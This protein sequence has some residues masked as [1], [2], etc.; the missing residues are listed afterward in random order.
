VKVRHLEEKI[1]GAC[2]GTLDGPVSE[3]QRLVEQLVG[4]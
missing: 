3:R 4:S 2:R 1:S